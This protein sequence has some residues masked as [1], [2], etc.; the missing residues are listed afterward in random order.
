MAK[1]S[2]EPLKQLFDDVPFLLDCEK[3]YLL[4]QGK[5]LETIKTYRKRHKKEFMN[6][7]GSI[8]SMIENE[9]NVPYMRL[10]E[11]LQEKLC[12]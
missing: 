7:L 2:Q 3:E 5:D 6:I 9:F 1:Y 10:L 11:E 8:F 4:K 12:A